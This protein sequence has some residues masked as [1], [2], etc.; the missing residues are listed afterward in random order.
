RPAAAHHTSRR[1]GAGGPGPPAYR[2][3]R[4]PEAAR[5]LLRTY[6]QLC[7]LHRDAA[8]SRLWPQTGNDRGPHGPDT[9]SRSSANSLLT[10]TGDL[11]TQKGA[12]SSFALSRHPA[13]R[14]LFAG[15]PVYENAPGAARNARAGLFRANAANATSRGGR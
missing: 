8:S 15:L 5:H 3:R 4:K 13:H 9:T 7:P 6:T 12:A 10:V 14:R 11:Q 1:S 2:Y